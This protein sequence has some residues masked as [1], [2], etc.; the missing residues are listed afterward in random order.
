MT[1][2]SSE[3]KILSVMMKNLIRGTETTTFT[4]IS[5]T[6]GFHI[7]S[8]GFVAAWKKLIHEL[9]YVE[10]ATPGAAQTTGEHQLT[11]AGIEYASTDEY[12][13]MVKDLN[14]VASTNDDH[15]E[16]LKKRMLNKYARGIFDLLLKHGTLDRKEMAGMMKTKDGSHG[17]SYGLKKLKDDGIV[18]V[19]A[20][21]GQKF[22]RKKL[23]LAD[24]AF[25][26][27]SDR[28]ETVPVDSEVLGKAIAHVKNIKH[29]DGPTKKKREN[30]DDSNNDDSPEKKKTKVE[31]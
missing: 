6:M 11:E 15:Q 20:G 28:P 24:K 8:K 10:P 21:E 27:P 22:K 29:R 7:R 30:D 14:Y 31:S 23:R 18:I 25:L 26:E 13:E 9:K 16:R 2:S 3:D 19:F 1:A 4:K 12:K 17:F 5:T